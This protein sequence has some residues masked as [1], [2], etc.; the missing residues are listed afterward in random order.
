MSVVESRA[1]DMRMDL[2]ALLGAVLSRWLRV[3]LVTVLLLGATFAVLMFV[4]KLYESSAGI[5]VEQ[6]SNAFT[7]SANEQASSSSSITQDSLM[8]SQIELIKSR[9]NLL[10][11][12]DQI[13]LR[14]VREFS[15]AGFSPVTFVMQLLGRKP[16]VKSVDQTVLENLSG[17]VTVLRERDSAIISIYVRSQDPQL[18]AT[19]A[20]AIANAHVQR[21]ADLSLADTAVASGWLEQE[22]AKLRTK[23]QEAET[24]VANYRSDND[25]FQSGTGTS[26]ILDQQLSNIATQITSA[27]ERKNSAQSRANLIRGLLDSGQP[28]DGVADVRNSLVIQNLIQSQATLQGELAQRSSTLL[29]NHPTIKALRA[30]I[31]SIQGQIAQ[32]GRKVAAALEAEAKIEANLEQS[33]N[34]DLARLKLSVST[35]TRDTVTL[36]SLQR[37]AKAQRDLLESYLAR[38]SDAAA[39]TDSSSA[40]P[41]VR[42]VTIAAPSVT[43]A[44]PKTALVLGAVGFIALALQIGAILFG[45]LM[46]GRAITQRH[47]V[48]VQ[49]AQP[50]VAPDDEPELFDDLDPEDAPAVAYEAAASHPFASAARRVEPD[51]EPEPAYEPEPYFDEA[52]PEPVSVIAETPEPAY[53]LEP[54]PEPEPVFEPTPEPE[55][56]T[57]FTAT[58]P[59]PEPAVRNAGAA[60]L[61]LSNLAADIAIGRVRVV[62]LAALNNFQDVEKVADT[63]V[64]SAIERGLSVASIDAGSARLSV[65]PG[66]TD[67]AAEKASFG[68][69][70]HKVTEGLAAV[71]WGHQDAIERRSMKPV[72]L[73]EALTDIYEVVIV[74]TGRMGVTS[75]LPVFSGIDCRLVLV[76]GDHADREAVQAALAEAATLGYEVGQMVSAPPQRSVA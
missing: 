47:R 34:D 37:D 69:V 6:R 52:E 70:V 53:E 28:I 56:V 22:I 33:L 65:E 57:T 66:L 72:T 29:G 20:N 46:S 24:A 10:T 55:P 54:L 44:S 7:R 12:I 39:R 30:Q 17:A 23:V 36:E 21:R 2:G 50:Y 40:L 5:L 14:D 63:L 4:P 27:Q 73:I 35:A 32:E 62:M 76:A 60:A 18:A 38:Y 51:A 15:G 9:D 61:E 19:I 59:Q 49:P 31:G 68:D 13:N 41:D 74:S 3:L 64:R 67:L 1:E 11:V 45:E 71:P 75:T 25:L 43:P 48:A 42:V 26:S 58:P 16:D 8:S